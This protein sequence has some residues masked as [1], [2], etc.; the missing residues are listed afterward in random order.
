MKTQCRSSRQEALGAKLMVSVGVRWALEI[1]ECL[2]DFVSC[3]TEPSEGFG[4]LGK[5]MEVVAQ[6]PN[7]LRHHRC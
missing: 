5:G 3:L 1:C 4:F 2:A 7:L 6:S